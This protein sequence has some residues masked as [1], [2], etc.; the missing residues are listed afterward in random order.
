MGKGVYEK[1]VFSLYVSF[2][3]D[4]T[5]YLE[6]WKN[7]FNLASR[8]LFEATSGKMKFGTIMAANRGRSFTPK[9]D[10]KKEA[11]V[12]I[13]G[14]KYTGSRLSCLASSC[15][16]V[17]PTWPYQNPCLG[18]AYRYFTLLHEDRWLV[19]YILHEFSHYALGLYDEYK[20]QLGYPG[21]TCCNDNDSSKC[22]MEVCD[23]I[24]TQYC[25]QEHT[26]DNQQEFMNHKSCWATIQEKYSDLA[27][28][29]ALS[30]YNIT[31][32]MG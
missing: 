3:Y 29:S 19:W 26:Q 20:N 13:Y 10:P 17:S 11:D 23:S 16:N 12:V 31:W 6:E 7:G 18:W 4:A 15:Y 27:G 28:P 21:G 8:S 2:D 14:P 30:D 22:I 25:D 24:V 1:G 5:K 9:V 32:V